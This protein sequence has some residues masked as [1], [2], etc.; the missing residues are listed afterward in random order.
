MYTSKKLVFKVFIIFLISSQLIYSQIDADYIK[1]VVLKSKSSNSFA[2]IFR[3][4]ESFSLSFDDVEA[5]EKDY[6]YKIE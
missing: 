6:H 5:D 3:L 2:P 4:G 1:T